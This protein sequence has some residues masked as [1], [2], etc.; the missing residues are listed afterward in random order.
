MISLFG[1]HFS[2]SAIPSR[3]LAE[4][5]VFILINLIALFFW[6]ATFIFILSFQRSDSCRFKSFVL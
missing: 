4:L 6:I 3:E 1:F 5:I 2:D